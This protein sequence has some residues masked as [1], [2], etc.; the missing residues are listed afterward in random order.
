MKRQTVLFSMHCFHCVNAGAVSVQK[1]E[2]GELLGTLFH[3]KAGTLHYTKRDEEDK[4][5]CSDPN[6]PHNYVTRTF[7]TFF[8]SHLRQMSERNVNVARFG[9]TQRF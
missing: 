9:F 8:I 7:L 5:G 3:F 6:A 2:E 4:S 1:C